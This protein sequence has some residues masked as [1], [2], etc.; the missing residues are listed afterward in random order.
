MDSATSGEPLLRDHT[1]IIRGSVIEGVVPSSS[2]SID[3]ETVDCR[4]KF[5]MPGLADMHGHLSDRS[6]GAIWLAHGITT[7][8]DMWGSPM[9][10]SWREEAR[11]DPLLPRVIAASPYLDAPVNGKPRYPGLV[12]VHDVAQARTAAELHIASGYDQLKVYSGLTL[13]QLQAIGRVA[14]EA[15]VPVVGHC[16][17]GVTYEQALAA[18]MRGFEHL[19][20]L[21]TGRGEAGLAQRE[22]MLTR[23]TALLETFDELDL[24]TLAERLRAADATVC[25]TLRVLRSLADTAEDHAEDLAL[26]QV[27]AAAVAR[28]TRGRL[29]PTDGVADQ[30]LQHAVRAV[31]EVYGKAAAVLHGAGVR[32]VAGT[33]AG[34]IWTVAGFSMADEL[35][36]LA[37]S[38]LTSHEVLRAATADP[39]DACGAAGEWGRLRPGAEADVLVLDDDPLSDPAVATRP[40]LVFRSGR[41]LAA[42]R[43]AELSRARAE[44]IETLLDLPT[45]E[46]GPMARPEWFGR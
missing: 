41:Q 35:R 6:Q 8:R 2:D 11:T 31:A 1:V 34:S 33:D 26:T 20:E 16:P 25:P 45:A 23:A 9:S 32:T 36:A 24:V 30:D 40:S 37:A 44:R 42:T 38:G 10:L 29:R 3:A 21:W 12:P 39:A 22:P 4:G 28:W 15:S 27:P 43:L 18:G 46:L 5:V 7:V 19:V 13:E 17:T 14:L